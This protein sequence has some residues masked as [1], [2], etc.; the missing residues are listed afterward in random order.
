M[1]SLQAALS[2]IWR[3]VYPPSHMIHT[4]NHQRSSTKTDMLHDDLAKAL[5]CA[6]GFAGPDF[7][8]LTKKAGPN[9]KTLPIRVKDA[10]GR[11]FNVDGLVQ[12][13]LGETLGKILV[14]AP[15]QSINKNANNALA[16][17][18]GSDVLRAL[19]KDGVD[20]VLIINACPAHALVL[21]KGSYVWEKTAPVYLNSELP[22]SGRTPLESYAID[23]AI[24]PRV[25]E[26]TI[27]Y[28]L[29]LGMPLSSITNPAQ[30][31]DAIDAKVKAGEIFIKVDVDC[32]E[33]YKFYIQNLLQ[34]S[35]NALHAQYLHERQTELLSE[36][37]RVVIDPVKKKALAPKVC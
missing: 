26:I 11:L 35:G 28:A 14:K 32:L 36:H 16:S 22:E 9:G 5:I 27:R 13:A 23:P 33:S 6:L 25:F 17:M 10:L 4:K 29:D 19:S 8:I 20:H 12:N 15:L 2:K 3:F 34:A 24:L 1:S 7:R 18:I 21:N 30:L 37:P 31:G